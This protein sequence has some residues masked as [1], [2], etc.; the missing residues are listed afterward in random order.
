MGHP[1]NNHE[2]LGHPV[3]NHGCLPSPNVR[4]ITGERGLEIGERNLEA[5]GRSGMPMKRACLPRIN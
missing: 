4:D 2:G 3:N 1:V 5:F